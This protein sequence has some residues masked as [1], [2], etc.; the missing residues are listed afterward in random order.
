MFAIVPRQVRKCTFFSLSI[1]LVMLTVT[2]IIDAAYGADEKCRTDDRQCVIEWFKDY[3]DRILNE[4]RRVRQLEPQIA[5][6]M[7]SGN[8]R[9]VAALQGQWLN[10][11]LYQHQ[12]VIKADAA[13]T[14]GIF[15]T[16]DALISDCRVAIIEL[17]Y[18]LLV[19]DRVKF[20]HDR[21]EY[22]KTARACEDKFQLGHPPSELRWYRA[23]R[24]PRSSAD[25]RSLPQPQ[26]I[27]SAEMVDKILRGAK[28][29][30][31]PVQLPVKFEMAVNVKTAR[32]IG[33][34][35][36]ESSCSVPTR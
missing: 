35:I 24:A 2:G 4:F 25:Y 36:P 15:D 21:A 14:A 12:S 3:R 11:R 29:A 8:D 7:R 23:R 1:V 13:A 16:Y 18:L 6:A 32:A 10:G 31:L 33:L 22:L 28:P 30:D 26:T 9:A 27:R 20:E 17:K 19:E 5:A 34:T